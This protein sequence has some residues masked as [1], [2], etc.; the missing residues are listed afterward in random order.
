MIRS[1]EQGFATDVDLQGRDSLSYSG[2]FGLG[3]AQQTLS[4]GSDSTVAS[5][6]TMDTVAQPPGFGQ[7]ATYVTANLAGRYDTRDSLGRPVRGTFAEI[8]A[9]ARDEVTGEH[10]SA[11]TFGGTVSQYVPV[12]GDHR[13]VVF[14]LS[15]AAAEPLVSG[16]TIPLDSLPQVSR[17]N[18]RGYDSNRFRDRYAIVGSIEYRFPVYE[19]LASSAGLD[20]FVFLD[21][22]TLWGATKF[23]DFPVHYSVGTGLRAGSQNDLSF[24]LTVG[25]SP[26]GFQFALGVEGL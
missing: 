5:L 12:L 17:L 26:D 14:T 25:V 19:Y 10:L 24:Q 4:P 13:T 16:D 18:D 1:N 2:V 8:S 3:L 7:K 21:T 23:S 6:T 11:I 22:G 9:L 20:S 15:G